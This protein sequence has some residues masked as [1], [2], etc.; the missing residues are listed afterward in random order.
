MKFLAKIAPKAQAAWQIGAIKP[1]LNLLLQPI[2]CRS[3][4]LF[5]F[6]PAQALTNHIARVQVC[7]GL[8]LL[9]HKLFE[10]WSQ[11]DFQGDRLARGTGV[12][13][14]PR[15][16]E[17]KTVSRI[18]FMRLNPG[19]PFGWRIQSLWDWRRGSPNLWVIERVSSRSPRRWR[20][21]R[22]SSCGTG[23]P[24]ALRAPSR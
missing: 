16:G 15:L 22:G 7:P 10:G 13:K 5:L 1:L 2:R 8:D 23:S 24:D 18:S 20:A 17:A 4:R 3:S 21:V 9:G 11:S 14:V 12:V 19:E 6:F